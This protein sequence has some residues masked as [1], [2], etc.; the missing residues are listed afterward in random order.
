MK[1]KQLIYVFYLFI[2]VGFLFNSCKKDDDDNNNNNNSDISYYQSRIGLEPTPAGTLSSVPTASNFTYSGQIPSSFYLDL[3]SP[4]NQGSQGSCVAWAAAYG[5]ISYHNEPPYYDSKLASPSFVY[6]QTKIG[7]CSEGSYFISNG[8]YKGALNLLVEKGVCSLADMPYN[9][10]DCSQ[11]PNTIQ[12]NNASDNKIVKYERVTDLSSD[13]IK[14]TLL[15]GYPILIGAELDLDF[16]NSNS[17]YVWVSNSSSFVG[18]HAM[19]IM[20]YDDSKSAF[21]I[22]N[23]WGTSWGDNGYGWIDYSNL[24]NVI[25]EAY[26][27]YAG[28]NEFSVTFDG[29]TYSATQSI[30]VAISGNSFFIRGESPENNIVYLKLE[31][32]SGVGNYNFSTT[33]TA[34]IEDINNFTYPKDEEI[35]FDYDN[36]IYDSHIN[37]RVQ[38]SGYDWITYEHNGSINISLFE[39]N[40]I[41]GTVNAVLYKQLVGNPT[42]RNFSA[43]FDIYY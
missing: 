13:N 12:I 4:S 16:C 6:N 35:R 29:Q 2:I 33:Y 24:S 39:S 8:Y 5:I 32:F 20:G 25:F 11:Q 10:S 15:S 40:R 22:L 34:T 9:E 1:K 17:S 42:P 41:A 26:I 21:K 18:N 36:S 37:R 38:S 27:L 28:S 43:S 14:K 23:S 3:P 31:N 7:D 30:H 19:V